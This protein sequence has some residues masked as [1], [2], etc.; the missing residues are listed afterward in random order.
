MVERGK[1]YG[2]MN[3]LKNGLG[4]VSR[5][6]SIGIATPIKMGAERIMG[7]VDSKIVQIEERIFKKISYLFIIGLGLFFLIFAL[8]FFL[9]ESLGWTK[10][11]TYFSMGAIVLIIGL[12]LKIREY[13]K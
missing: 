12:T 10:S 11:V 2:F 6:S 4:Y 13:D 9:I 5:I 3:K 1:K 7:N 8:S